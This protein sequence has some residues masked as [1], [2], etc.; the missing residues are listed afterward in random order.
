MVGFSVTL[1]SKHLGTTEQVTNLNFKKCY[2]VA[3]ELYI[4]FQHGIMQIPNA[5]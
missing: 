5:G 1:I 2:L 3:N 4:S